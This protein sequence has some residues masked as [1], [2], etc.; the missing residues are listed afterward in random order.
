MP[1]VGASPIYR[2]PIVGEPLCLREDGHWS[3]EG[4][5]AYW[6]IN[7][8]RGTVVRDATGRGPGTMLGPWAWRAG[9]LRGS[10]DLLT[11]ID[12]GLRPL[13]AA[14]AT[15]LLRVAG[16]MPADLYQHAISVRDNAVVAWSIGAHIADGG[17]RVW[18]AGAS[19][20]LELALV[21]EAQ[22]TEPRWYN[23]ACVYEGTVGTIYVDG[24]FDSSGT[25]V[26][27]GAATATV[28]VCI[29]A[30]W[31]VYPTP[32]GCLDGCIGRTS[33]YE[34]ALSADEIRAL[35]AAPDL[36]IWRP[37]RGVSLAMLGEIVQDVTPSGFTESSTFGTPVLKQD[38]EPAGIAVTQTFG[39]SKISQHLEAA[40][41]AAS[42]TFGTVTLTQH[43]EAVGI[44][45]ESL[46][47]IPTLQWVQDLTPTGL[48]V[49]I[50]LGTSGFAALRITPEGF[51]TSSTF[52]T[53]QLRQHLEAVG[54]ATGTT[55]GQAALQWI[56]DLEPTGY[57]VS[58][59]FGAPSIIAP[60]ELLP[61]GMSVPV[62]FGAPT[63]GGGSI[64]PT[65]FTVPI[66]AGT[67]ALQLQIEPPGYAVSTTF[68][69][70]VVVALEVNTSTSVWSF[71][72][73][74]RGV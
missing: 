31:N 25:I 42:P 56:T 20:N 52:G 48:E 11:A 43:L 66:T 57:A 51:A 26:A 22:L 13:P 49:P 29:G 30:R 54:F 7:E 12:G 17:R 63:L 2:P 73:A 50:T 34:R 21:S 19:S 70:A 28:P 1:P 15:V 41:I 69:T 14:G 23:V 40:G 62:T 33:L 45:L 53:A 10:R 27:M 4:L 60:A 47:G 32:G 39:T 38:L 61:G 74:R 67:A 9:G 46:L 68:G 65:G 44:A 3:T 16:G 55:F 72:R 5:I 71:V 59:T 6:P 64:A 36:P 8:M 58:V 37:R 24:E 35:H 18:L